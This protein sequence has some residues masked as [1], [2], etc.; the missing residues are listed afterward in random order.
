MNA[1]LDKVIR[2]EAHGETADGKGITDQR[3]CRVERLSQKAPG[4]V[5]LH[6]RRGKHPAHVAWPRLR[7]NLP[8]PIGPRRV[9]LS[10]TSKGHRGG[11][12]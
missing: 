4:A 5:N 10:S 7:L 11:S 1:T 3:V 2:E 9:T 12:V 8:L 6:R